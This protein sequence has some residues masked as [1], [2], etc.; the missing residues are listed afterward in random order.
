M[1]PYSEQKSWSV[2]CWPQLEIQQSH[3]KKF[4]EGCQGHGEKI[5]LNIRVVKVM[6]EKIGLNMADTLD[7]RGWA[8]LAWRKSDILSG[9]VEE[10]KESSWVK[11]NI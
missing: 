4:Y 5:G 9:M 11:V 7:V 1:Q 6:E 2:R 10:K 3:G 8:G